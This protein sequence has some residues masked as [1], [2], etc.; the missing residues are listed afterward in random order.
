MSLFTKIRQRLCRHEWRVS[1]F[2]ALVPGTSC[3]CVKC[4]TVEQRYSG[5]AITA[6]AEGRS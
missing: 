2:Q 4:G 5:G 6:K 3:E 1:R